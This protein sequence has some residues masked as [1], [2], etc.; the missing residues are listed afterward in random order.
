MRDLSIFDKLDDFSKNHSFS[1]LHF[2]HQKLN[3]TNLIDSII[4]HLGYVDIESDENNAPLLKEQFNLYFS[5]YNTERFLKTNK[6]SFSVHE[7]IG[8]LDGFGMK[9]EHKY[10]YHGLEQFI[11]DSSFL[12][13]IVWAVLLYRINY[14]KGVFSNIKE[15]FFPYTDYSFSCSLD[16]IEKELIAHKDYEYHLL[17]L[18]L[19]IEEM[20]RNEINARTSDPFEKMPF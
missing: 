5:E 20:S 11:N 9:M 12:S 17:N 15:T 14:R 13:D 8:L 6:H 10:S 4:L 7:M 3:T 16:D 19:L 18:Q 2:V 1:I